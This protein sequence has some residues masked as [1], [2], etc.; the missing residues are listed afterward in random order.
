M[1]DE[2]L[3]Y[4]VNCSDDDDESSECSRDEDTSIETKLV[5]IKAYVSKMEEV[6][7]AIR[8]SQT[9]VKKQV[10]LDKPP[11]AAGATLPFNMSTKEKIEVDGRS[12]YV[13]NVDYGATAEELAQHF[14]GCGFVNKVTIL[15]NKYNGH[16]KGFAYMEFAEK[17][18]VEVAMALDDS[19][20]RGRQLKVR[21]K[22]SNRPGITTSNRPPPRV[23]RA[24]DRGP[25]NFYS[26]YRPMRPPYRSRKVFYSPY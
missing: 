6:L 22:R 5:E 3:I 12:I 15:T 1:E 14:Q 13:G 21:P 11:G 17:D 20:F 18:S 7:K 9:K 24:F 2:E 25:R 10:T 23:I 8:Q 19:L 26:G 16:P 4:D